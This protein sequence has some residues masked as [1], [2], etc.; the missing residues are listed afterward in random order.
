MLHRS[1]TVP[2]WGPLPIFLIPLSMTGPLCIP[3]RFPLPLPAVSP[4]AQPLPSHL[5][6]AG[7]AH[8]SISWAGATLVDA[9][10]LLAWSHATAELGLP[11]CTSNTAWCVH[12]DGV[13]VVQEP[14]DTCTCPGLKTGGKTG[15]S[16]EG[17]DGKT[18]VRLSSCRNKTENT[19]AAH[20]LV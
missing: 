11:S 8:P 6:G 17:I 5:H 14:G 20:N 1:C 9:L 16:M 10:G 3:P 19:S 15:L 7:V 4:P 12:S 2:G 13:A 18:S